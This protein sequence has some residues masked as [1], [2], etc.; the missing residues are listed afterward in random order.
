MS[1]ATLEQIAAAADV[2]LDGIANTIVNAAPTDA[3]RQAFLRGLMHRINANAAAP[4]Q[5]TV[6]EITR[7]LGSW[8]VSLQLAADPTF[9]AAD[10]EASKL[11]AAGKIGEGL[12]RRDLRSHYSR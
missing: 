2:D 11:L 6:F 7:W 4:S 9:S 12:S 1:G 3:D 8:M 5:E 10:D